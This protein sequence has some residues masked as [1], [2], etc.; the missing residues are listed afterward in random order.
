[1]IKLSKI[2]PNI[3]LLIGIITLNFYTY[4]INAYVL[5]LFYS[6]IIALFLFVKKKL[7]YPKKQKSL[8]WIKLYIIVIILSVVRGVFVAE[9]YWDYRALIFN[10][11]GMFMIFAVYISL[12]PYL[13]QRTLSVYLKYA[14]FIY[15]IQIPFLFDLRLYGMFI[16]P[17]AF[18]LLFTPAIPGFWRIV[19]VGITVI[20]LS[21]ILSSRAVVLKIAMSFL[22]SLLF[23]VRFFLN[24]RILNTVSLFIFLMPAIFFLLAIL[25]P[26][27]IFNIG[28]YVKSDIKTEGNVGNEDEQDLLADT[29]RTMFFVDA[30]VTAVKY[31]SWLIGRTPARGIETNFLAD[32]YIALTGRAER[33]ASEIGIINIFTWMGLIGVILYFLILA[34]GSYLAINKSNNFWAKIFG[35]YIAFRW[36]IVWIEDRNDFTMNH[37]VLMLM[38]GLV[39]SEWFRKMNNEEVEIWIKGIFYKKYRLKKYYQ[40]K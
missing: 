21:L 15:L 13:L 2:I 32:Y 10:A 26:F 22:L 3:I 5:W 23:Y 38:V 29:G 16:Y 9:I 25:T 17:L 30:L 18:I 20:L 39:Y 31:D 34:K 6:M 7:T 28:E 36:L 27:N 4:L 35:L 37:F 1:M 40:W 11:F 33:V 8:I 12:N 24:K 19:L 14:F